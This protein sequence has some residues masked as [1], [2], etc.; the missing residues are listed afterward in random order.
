MVN[1]L[2][3]QKKGIKSWACDHCA[4]YKSYQDNGFSYATN[5][6]FKQAHLFTTRSLSM[7]HWDFQLRADN[8]FFFMW[9]F[10]EKENNTQM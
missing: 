6:A 2:F 8:L 9:I 4:I 10:Q 5:T 3:W 1:D 7:R